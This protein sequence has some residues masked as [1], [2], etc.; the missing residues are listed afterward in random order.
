ML[1][2]LGRADQVDAAGLRR[3]VGSINRYL[4]EPDTGADG[5]EATGT[6]EAAPGCD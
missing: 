6:A 5:A 4:G 3:L 1:I 2:N